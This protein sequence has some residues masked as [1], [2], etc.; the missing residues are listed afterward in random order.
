MQFDC[1]AIWSAMHF[2]SSTKSFCGGDIFNTEKWKDF[3]FW[4]SPTGNMFGHFCPLNINNLIPKFFIKILSKFHCHFNPMNH[5]IWFIWPINYGWYRLAGVITWWRARH[6]FRC[7]FELCKI[8]E[9]RN[10]QLREQFLTDHEVSCMKP[11]C[12]KQ[13]C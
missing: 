11:S 13:I 7:G 3:S 5:I 6:D 2:L 9:W 10:Q 1:S 12:A 8:G 4:N